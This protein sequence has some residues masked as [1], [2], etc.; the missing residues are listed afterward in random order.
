MTE[1]RMLPPTTLQGARV[2]VVGL[3][4]SGAA[5]SR[6]LARQGA[7]VTGT[8]RK[9]DLPA[10]DLLS[11]EGV[12]VR[13]GPYDP[14]LLDGVDIVV[15]SP[16]VSSEGPFPEAAMQRGQRVVSEVEAASWFLEGRLVGITGSNGK[17][18]TT[19]LL[20]HICRECGMPVDVCG[21]IGRP[22]SKA[23]MEHPD[24]ALFIAEL[25]SFQLERPTSFA[26]A[27]AILLNL[28][29]DHLDRHGTF[30]AYR[31][32]KLR[33]F[34]N[35]DESMTAI[36]NGDDPACRERLGTISAKTLLFTCRKPGETSFHGAFLDAAGEVVLAPTG[37]IAG[38]IAKEAFPLP[39]RHNRENLM[40][41]LLAAL[42]LGIPFDEAAKAAASFQ[43]VPHRI[44][45]VAEHGGIRFV[46]D[47]KATN[48]DAVRTAL[49]AI[50]TPVVLLLGGRDKGADFSD[51][52]PELSER[53]AGG[54]LRLVIAFGEAVDAIEAALKGQV[55]FRRE[56][57]FHEVVEASVEAAIR[58]DTV[59]LSPGCASFDMFR[60]FEHRGEEF[61]REVRR[62]LAS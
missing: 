29:P 51:L 53:H 30:E 42:E 59:L 23:V 9:P 2:L 43:G 27:I 58:G 39:G 52:L 25:S 46:N 20:G 61:R 48:L 18:T 8:D 37:E 47:S 56:V 40:A 3:G 17:T 38:R 33:I 5:V 62:C 22:L 44:E 31:D 28:T 55:P 16:G 36:L 41:A 60:D 14:A 10:V 4:K 12:E 34:E 45:L 24:G 15:L 11:R 13:L 26:P 19:A 49:L 21:N 57:S 50:E 6:L 7:R 1:R 35:Q 54:R 32:C